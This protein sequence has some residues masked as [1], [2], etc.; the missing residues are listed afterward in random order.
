MCEVVSMAIRTHVPIFKVQLT[1]P[2]MALEGNWDMSFRRK[3]VF[4]HLEA[5]RCL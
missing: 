3:G 1:C 4:S 5:R 2:Q